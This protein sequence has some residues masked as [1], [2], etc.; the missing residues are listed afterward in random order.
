VNMHNN[1][2]VWT[3]QKKIKKVVQ[4]SGSRF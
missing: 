3:G 1:L 2:I 4:R